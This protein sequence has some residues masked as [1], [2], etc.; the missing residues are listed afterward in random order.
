MREDQNNNQVLADAVAAS[1]EV[2]DIDGRPMLV[3]PAGYTVHDMEK[4]LP[5][6]TRE[7]GSM[8][9]RD[10]ASFI[11]YFNKFKSDASAIYAQVDPSKFLGVMNGHLPGAPGW[12]DFTVAYACPHS[13]EWQ[14]WIGKDGSPMSQVAF[15]EFIEENFPNIH[16]EGSMP[17]GADM[18]QIANTFQAKTKVNFASGV[19][20]DNGNIDLTFQEDTAAGAGPRGSIKIPPAFFI[21]IPVFENGTVWQIEAKFRY[22]IKDGVLSMWY[23]LVRPHKTLEAAFKGV[24]KDVEEG[25]GVK[26]F[27]A[28]V[29]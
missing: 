1:L 10:T 11:A 12:E 29:K 22:R 13:K 16:G 27:N 28:V 3:V 26:L 8:A 5:A 24:W 14:T 7:R 19:R 2:R 4:Y 23:D 9:M 17:S 20:L 18:L 15:A 25:T 6:P 21:A